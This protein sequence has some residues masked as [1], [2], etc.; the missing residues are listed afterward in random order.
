MAHSL[1]DVLS[2]EVAAS[3]NLYDPA[4]RPGWFGLDHKPQQQQQTLVTRSGARYVQVDPSE[5]LRSRTVTSVDDDRPGRELTH[6]KAAGDCAL[7]LVTSRFMEAVLGEKPGWIF[8]IDDMSVTTKTTRRRLYDVIH[9]LSV[10]RAVKRVAPGTY[11][12]IGLAEV[13]QAF[14]DVRSF[15][16]LAEWKLA[17]SKFN[18]RE[19]KQYDDESGR[20][21][22]PMLAATRYT[23]SVLIAGGTDAVMAV[24][25]PRAFVRYMAKD[26]RDRSDPVYRRI[27]DVIQVL[28]V[29]NFFNHPIVRKIANSEL[30]V[31]APG[32]AIPV[33]GAKYQKFEESS[34]EDDEATIGSPIPAPRPPSFAFVV[35]AFPPPLETFPVAAESSESSPTKKRAREE[36]DEEVQFMEHSN[37]CSETAL[38]GL[39]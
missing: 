38:L 35:K 26:L 27:Y 31:P 14:I 21:A 33:A 7:R 19:P 34:S 18:K 37:L 3:V 20:P 15:G 11:Q 6:S 2:P 13:Y 23:I 8:R 36:E 9:I 22:S 30:R 39:L 1:T 17:T 12:W 5:M 32:E 25:S 28:T 24:E 29:S 10:T 4:F 16:T